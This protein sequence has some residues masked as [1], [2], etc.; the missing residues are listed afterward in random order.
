MRQVPIENNRVDND[1]VSE[2]VPMFNVDCIL[3]TVPVCVTPSQLTV[4]TVNYGQK[5]MYQ[6]N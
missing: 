6:K 3:Y 5:I 4:N 1:H 2:N